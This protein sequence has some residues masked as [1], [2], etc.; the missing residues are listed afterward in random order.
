MD[1]DLLHVEVQASN[2]RKRNWFLWALAFAVVL[3][4]CAAVPLLYLPLVATLGQL[5]PA[6]A[7]TAEHAYYILVGLTGLVVIFC[8]Y[9]VLKQHELE[10]MRVTLVREAQETEQGRT[11]LLELSSM[12]QLAT[13]LNLQLSLEVVLEIIVRRVV[14]AMRAQQASIMLT[15]NETGEL[16]TRAAYGL[17]A[18]FAR[19]ARVRLGENIAGRVAESGQP[20]LLNPGE[21]GESEFGRHFKNDRNITSALSLPLRVGQRCVGVLNVNRINHPESFEEHHREILSM[22][23][24]HVAAVI[25]RAETLDKLGS[26]SRELEAANAHLIQLNTMKDL[27]L[28]TASHELKTPLTSVIGYAELLDDQGQRLTQ[29]QRAEFLGRLR[30]EAERLMSLIEDILDLTRLESG[31]FSLNKTP[32]AVSEVAR[33]A[34]ETMRGLAGKHGVAI[35]E[36]YETG[37]PELLLD[38]VKMRQVVTNL[39]TNAVK[40]SPSGGTVDV[41]VSREP[42]WVRIDVADHGPGVSPDEATHIFELFGQGVS[43]VARA[44]AGVGIGLHLVKRI[45]ELHGGHVGVNSVPGEGSTFWVRLP[46]TLAKAAEPALLDQAA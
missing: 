45:S 7:P 37:L 22:F 33:E 29:A 19:N 30:T 6:Q 26:R 25:E 31:K 13:T 3:G 16:V 27:F 28:S 32:F 43:E 41:R 38:E 40:F 18:E 20:V 21:S 36:S 44:D 4:L 1:P 8:L 23:A 17:E 35:R 5:D 24:E 46:I 34:V 14:S 2:I 9:L 10:R 15:N 39:L 12:F 42:R 11:R